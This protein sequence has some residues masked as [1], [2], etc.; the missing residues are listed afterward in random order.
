[1][2]AYAA[3]SFYHSVNRAAGV[4]PVL[5]PPITAKTFC[6]Y[7]LEGQDLIY[8]KLHGYPGIPILYG[9][10]NT[11]ALDISSIVNAT[12]GGVTIFAP[13][14][15]LRRSSLFNAFFYSGARYVIA[16][17]GTNYAAVD[18]V[19]GADRLGLWLRRLMQWGFSTPLAFHIARYRVLLSTSQAARDT[20]G[21]KLYT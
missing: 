12:L 7:W 21:F 10:D 4:A 1:M 6:Y 13:T 16:G 3:Q 15:H 18:Q 9:D 17:E 20:F 19:A 11:P 2:F 14:C 8:L 5:S